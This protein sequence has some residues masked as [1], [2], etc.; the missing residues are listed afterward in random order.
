MKTTE[1]NTTDSLRAISDEDL[2]AVV[3]GFQVYT[4]GG[5]GTMA[6]GKVVGS[7][8]NGNDIIA[9]FLIAGEVIGV[10]SLL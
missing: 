4:G 10:L 6:H 2:G 8:P 5:S 7:R 1:L 9:G 3:G